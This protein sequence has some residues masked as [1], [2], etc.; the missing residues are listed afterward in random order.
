MKTFS[1]VTHFYKKSTHFVSW[2]ATQ[3]PQN[4]T[5]TVTPVVIEEQHKNAS[6]HC[7]L[8]FF[9][10]YKRFDSWTVFTQYILCSV[11]FVDQK[12]IEKL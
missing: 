4:Y 10:S 7:Y 9:L 5:E 11:P 12:P 2:F 8:D 6:K 1:Y 3:L